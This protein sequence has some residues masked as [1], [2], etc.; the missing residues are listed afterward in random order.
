[1]NE[2]D[3]F[4]LFF[5]PCT[6]KRNSERVAAM[7]GDDWRY[8]RQGKFWR[9]WNGKVW[10]EM[11]ELALVKP[12]I[13]CFRQ[14]S[15][16]NFT[17]Q[18]IKQNPNITKIR[19]F[20][21][22]S[23]NT[24]RVTGCIKM[25]RA[26]LSADIEMFDCNENLFNMN[27][28]T[29]DLER[30]VARSHHREDYLTQ[31]SPANYCKSY[32]TGLWLK[33]INEVLPDP[34]TRRYFQKYCGYC[35]SGSTESEKFIVLYGGGGG[36]KGTV[37]ETIAACLGKDYTVTLSV[38][39]LLAG[40]RI[41]GGSEHNSEIAKLKGK[42]L[43][44]SSETSKGC[45]FDDAKIKKLTGSDT[46]TARMPHGLPF[47]YQPQ[48]KLTIQTNFLP[49]I[50][51]IFDAGMK[52]RLVIIPFDSTISIRNTKLKK[53]LITKNELD[54]CFQ[55]LKEGYDL[56]KREGLPDYDGTG[57][58]VKMKEVMKDFYDQNDTLSEFITETYYEEPGQTIPA[59]TVFSTYLT[60]AAGDKSSFGRNTFYR[61]MAKRGH[62]RL[63]ERSGDVI[64]GL[65]QK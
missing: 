3:L 9:H 33:T 18:Q 49:A 32:N 15:D 2:N 23:E 26:E 35:L 59:S 40:Q 28:C 57:F 41:S 58:P 25:L 61:E 62:R 17:E 43:V 6:D 46:I 12:V 45:K 16:I 64:E 52:R 5:L 20:L 60:W 37:M 65:M 42:R 48:F 27:D 14:L 53:E 39:A 31:I 55:W 4:K 54:A 7:I 50:E 21:L 47:D 1:M 56:W 51:D 13:D 29:L 30:G 8:V 10:E 19:K 44:L 36:G 63:H 11:D 38:N 22:S 24:N 34:E